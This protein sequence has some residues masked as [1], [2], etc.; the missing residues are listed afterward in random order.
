MGLRRV[1]APVSYPVTIEEARARCRVI[2]TEEDATL[3]AL[4][5]AATA[6][7]ESYTGRSL[8]PQTWE[9]ALD[10]FE[11]SILLSRGPVTGIESVTY[12]DLDEVEQTLSASAYA[13][14]DV[15]DPQWLVRATDASWP[16]VASGVNNVSIRFTAG[17]AED[18]AEL[19]LA[20]QAML[21]LIVQWFDNP[22]TVL[23]GSIVA[24]MP[25]AVDAL[26]T[27]LRSFS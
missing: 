16:A 14:D 5:A 2:G 26:L 20:K 11:D 10:A 1:T 7:V 6:F 25:H 18:A 12:F 9:L 4:I 8:M 15:S 19:A 17:Y 21:M 13:L 22:S 3:T 23:T 27:N 24:P